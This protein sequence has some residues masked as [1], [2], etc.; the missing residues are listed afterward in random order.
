M[1]DARK[2]FLVFMEER[3]KAGSA[4]VNGDAGPVLSLTTAADPSSFYGPGGGH[5]EGASKVRSSHEDGAKAFADGSWTELEVLHADASG[6]L[7]YWTGLQHAKVHFKGRDGEVPMK[8]RITELF[9][10]EGGAW[11]MIHRHADPMGDEQKKP[12]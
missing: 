10:R 3:K 4:Y 11:K 7:A 6:D 8:L 1:D 2:S 12:G 9:R 5:I